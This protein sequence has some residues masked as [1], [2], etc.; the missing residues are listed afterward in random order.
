MS[1]LVG[2]QEILYG[3]GEEHLYHMLHVLALCAPTPAEGSVSGAPE[4]FGMLGERTMRGEMTLVVLPWPTP[5]IQ[6]LARSVSRIFHV[7]ELS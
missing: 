7:W 5:S 1:L 2:E 4:G 3:E 6:R